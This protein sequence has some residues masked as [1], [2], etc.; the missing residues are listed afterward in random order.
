[1]FNFTPRVVIVQRGFRGNWESDI[2]G[3][4]FLWINNQV[5]QQSSFSCNT[6]YPTEA[7]LSFNLS[8]HTLIWYIASKS[9]YN[10]YQLNMNN[11]TFFW[12]CF[13]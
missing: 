5:F 3:S 1:M 2:Y 6:S 8:Y 13:G 10:E 12:V 11:S 7:K 4:G 9:S